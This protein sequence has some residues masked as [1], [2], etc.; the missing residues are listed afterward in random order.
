MVQRN[1]KRNLNNVPDT[2]I[3]LFEYLYEQAKQ[4][5]DMIYFI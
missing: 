2:V 1:I 5:C 4:N 3:Q